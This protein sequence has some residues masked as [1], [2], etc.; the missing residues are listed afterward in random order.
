MPVVRIL[1]A[2]TA[3]ITLSL[4]GAP[5]AGAQEPDDTLE[6][7]ADTIYADLVQ[8]VSEREDL[9]TLRQAIEAAGLTETLRQEGP[10]TIMGAT[11]EAFDALAPGELDALLDD[12]ERLRQVVLYHIIRGRVTASEARGLAEA[13]TEEG[14]D[15]AIREEG[16][17]LRINDATVQDTD[18]EAED[19]GIIHTIDRVLIPPERVTK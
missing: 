18:I 3:C 1:G 10:W 5:G 12:R 9:S 15:I 17:D 7:R 8:A 13:T 2:L 14:S 16:G 19:D 11:N 4:M 6:V